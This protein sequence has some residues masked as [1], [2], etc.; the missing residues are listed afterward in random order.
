MRKY[1]YVLNG[2][3]LKLAVL[4]AMMAMTAL[5]T[6]L[7]VYYN[8]VI[9]N[10]F[11]Y[12]ENLMHLVIPV[13]VLTIMGIGLNTVAY[14]Q[15]LF[16]VT[17]RQKLTFKFKIHLLQHLQKIDFIDFKKME[18]TYLSKRIDD[19]TQQVVDFFINNFAK[20]PITLVDITA[21]IWL[22]FRTNI[23]IGVLLIIAIP[24]HFWAN[25]YFS[26][27]VFKYNAEY[28][29]ETAQLFKDYTH[30]LV[31]MEEI[32]IEARFDVEEKE[33]KFGF[34]RFLKMLKKDLFAR[35]NMNAFQQISMDILQGAVFFVGAMAVINGTTSPGMVLMAMHYFGRNL[36][37]IGY[38]LGLSQELEVTKSAVSRIDELKE[39]RTVEEGQKLLNEV[40]SI[41][42][43]VS[44]AIEGSK[45]LNDVRVEAQKGDIVL[46]TG[47][48]G[49]GKSTLTKL[50]VGVIK[51]LN[52][53][54]IM[55]NG[56]RDLTQ[57]DAQHLRS[58]TISYV[59]QNLSF[60]DITVAKYFEGVD[61]SRYKELLKEFWN[62]EINRL[63][64]GQKQLCAIVRAI[65]QKKDILIMDEPTSA[66]DQDKIEWF[67]NEIEKVGADK[68]TFIITHE[69]ALKEKFDKVVNL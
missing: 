31:H 12:F 13:V 11:F 69:K 43:Q 58:R 21:I 65:S 30:Q 10:R 38:F 60:K 34:Q 2:F 59:P 48:N 42:A 7:T 49:T 39:I 18:A 47:R 52:K 3:R 14:F 28:R 40:S 61:V 24:F 17:L 35:L 36:G 15:S 67:T 16:S 27:P 41:Q 25:H 68:I 29:E 5:G 23:Y 62:E 8:G 53:S 66:L 19:D 50:L 44:Y 22:L 37:N 9:I 64:G 57:L 26:K 51:P 20:F 1:L 56:S 45:I 46:L 63:S 55:I 4:F 6:L 54:R 33:L 32:L